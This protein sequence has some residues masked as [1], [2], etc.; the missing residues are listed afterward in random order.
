MA[1]AVI[2]HAISIVLV[3]IPSFAVVVSPDFV[4][5]ESQQ[6]IY[7]TGIVHAI[8][9]ASAFLLGLGLVAAWRFKKDIRGCFRRKKFMLATFA[10]WVV[11]IVLGIVL[12]AVFYGPLLFG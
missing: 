6:Y 9:G 1:G 3:M 11:A 7:I 8:A 2:L 5:P 4:L 12:F 10:L